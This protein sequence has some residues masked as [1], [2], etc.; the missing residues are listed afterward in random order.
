MDASGS[1]SNYDAAIYDLKPNYLNYVYGIGSQYGY[2][3]RFTLLIATEDGTNI[4][5]NPVEL[6]FFTT[7]SK[8]NG[9]ALGF[10]PSGGRIIYYFYAKS[11]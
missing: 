9:Y 7:V 2:T 10:P 6:R 11:T 1:T 3:G 4:G 5:C 8:F